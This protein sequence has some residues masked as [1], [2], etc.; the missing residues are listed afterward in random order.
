M[1]EKHSKIKAYLTEL[2][3]LDKNGE[4]KKSEISLLYKTHKDVKIAAEHGNPLCPN[5]TTGSVML[6][7][8]KVQIYGADNFKQFVE[9][10]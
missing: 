1:K 10:G 7:K 4:Q 2:A 6:V 9:F 3:V 5:S 8:M